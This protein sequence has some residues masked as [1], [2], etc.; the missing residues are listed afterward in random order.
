VLVLVL[1]LLSLLVSIPV[2]VIGILV[3]SHAHR[4]L[5]SD[6]APQSAMHGLEVEVE[7]EVEVLVEVEEVEEVLLRPSTCHGAV[8]DGREG[9]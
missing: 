4:A 7:E 3:I 2:F 1:L 6:A 9:N 8:T 5:I